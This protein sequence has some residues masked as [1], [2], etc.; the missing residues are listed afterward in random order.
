MWVVGLGLGFPPYTR[1]G[2]WKHK[3]L[4]RKG[5]MS[6]PSWSIM[7][8]QELLAWHRRSSPLV[9]VQDELSGKGSQVPIYIGEQRHDSYCTSEMCQHGMHIFS[10]CM[11]LCTR[12]SDIPHFR[13]S[14][15]TRILEQLLSL[16]NQRGF[17]IVNYNENPE[18][19][20][21]LFKICD[22]SR[23]EENITIWFAVIQL[24]L[25][26]FCQICNKKR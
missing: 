18:W 2:C 11:L 25:S 6:E 15:E 23:V 19:A 24:F 22:A 13:E 8:D 12:I 20:W 9:L 7:C 26:T 1:K 5:E 21:T 17:S 14:E 3:L 16:W 4:G 10:I